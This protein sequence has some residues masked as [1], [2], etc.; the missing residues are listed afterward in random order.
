M[1]D[2]C[3]HLLVALF[4]PQPNDLD[5]LRGAVCGQEAPLAELPAL[6]QVDALRKA[7][8]VLSFRNARLY[9][10]CLGA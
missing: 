6:A 2:A 9:T 7:S 8:G 3:R 5:A 1:S 4:D 10:W